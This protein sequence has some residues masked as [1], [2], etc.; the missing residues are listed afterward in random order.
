ME[1][2]VDEDLRSDRL[3]LDSREVA[4]L[5]GLGRTKVFQMMAQEELP[6]VRIGR[7]VRVP[8]ASL[9]EWLR[10]RTRQRSQAADSLRIDPKTIDFR[11]WRRK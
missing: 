5:L 2:K 7:T 9:E 3:L 10:D 4:A 8:R 11:A 6:V 1:T